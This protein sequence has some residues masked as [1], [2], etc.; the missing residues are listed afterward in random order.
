MASQ[1]SQPLP[2]RDTYNLSLTATPEQ[3][4][5]LVSGVLAGNKP[6][7]ESPQCQL[8]ALRQV[9]RGSVHIDRDPEEPVWEGFGEGW[10]LWEIAKPNEVDVP[11]TRIYQLGAVITAQGVRFS[12]AGPGKPEELQLLNATIRTNEVLA[13]TEMPSS[14]G[15]VLASAHNIDL[16]GGTFTLKQEELS[17]QRRNASDNFVGITPLGF[18]D[19]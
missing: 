2:Q 19:L 3:I 5:D 15:E 7:I 18:T 13:P 4:T 8:F 9:W 17:L 1:D 14:Y 11:P 12:S 10:N 6:E 16:S